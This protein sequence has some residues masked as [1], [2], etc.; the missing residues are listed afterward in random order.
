MHTNI[1]DSA[2]NLEDRRVAICK[3]LFN[4]MKDVDH[5]I[6]KM[7]PAKK[8]NVHNVRDFKEYP[9][10]TIHTNRFKNTFLPFAL[11]NLQ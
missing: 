8:E 11:F 3:K 6:F 1:N 9:T 7:L 5:K 10:P 4:D 2:P